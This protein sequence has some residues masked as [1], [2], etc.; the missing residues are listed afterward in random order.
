V[1][2]EEGDPVKRRSKIVAGA[3]VVVLAG[4][5]FYTRYHSRASAS[6]AALRTVS[7]Q[8]GLVQQTAS[9][10]GTVTAPT[11]LTL[12]F[13]NSGLLTSLNVSLGQTV[14]VGQVLAAEDATTANNQL[15]QA[16]ANLIAAQ[17][18]LQ[19][20]QEGLTAA[21]KA[22]D[23]VA[24]TQAQSALTQAQTSLAD[25]QASIAQDA[26]NL[27][28][29]V[30]QAQTTLNAAQATQSQDATTNAAA[31]A[32]AQAQLAADQAAPNPNATTIAKDESDLAAAQAAQQ[33]ATTKDSTS[34]QQ[35][36]DALT[37]AMNVQSTGT[38]KDTQS[39]HTAENAV[40]NA[41]NALAATLAANAVKEAPPLPGDL[42][43]AEAAV[44]T[45]QSTVAQDQTLVDETTLVSP[46]A[47]VVAAISTQPGELVSGGGTTSSSSS[48]TTSSS[49]SKGFIEITGVNN[50]QVTAGFAETDAANLKVTQPATISF[51]A[52][53]SVSLAGHVVSVNT[54]PTV[55]SNVVTYNATIAFDQTSPLVKDGMSANVNVVVN[56]VNAEYVPSLAVKSV[57]GNSTVT[58]LVNGKQATVPISVG[59]VGDTN[60]QILG[61]VA[62]GTTVVL[63]SLTTTTP[64]TTNNSTTPAG[65]GGGFGGGAGGGLRLGG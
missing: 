13:Q 28:A 11:D 6:T 53:P 4:G 24:A 10:A 59:L 45:G 64:T 3:A 20:L 35:A 39:R 60:T 63:P 40:T 62:A 9:A 47:G 54:Q 43:T 55:V 41:Q 25:T 44:T 52:L 38:L 32:A 50:L 22:Q 31:V 46:V 34:V 27:Q 12:N 8:N 61:G 42:A 33:S 18:K 30:N 7:V 51:N 48:T 5:F 2:R 65:G 17:A 37:G 15:A 21:Q 26:R 36:Q 23:Q 1:T 57:G 19:Q 14:T 29:A 16:K 49:T 56:Q 58:T